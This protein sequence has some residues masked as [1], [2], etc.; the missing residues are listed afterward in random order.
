MKLFNYKG[1]SQ[2]Y[3]IGPIVVKNVC[4]ADLNIGVAKLPPGGVKRID[5]DHLLPGTPVHDLW[6]QGF[7]D[8]VKWPDDID[9]E[10]FQPISQANGPTH[11][12]LPLG[13]TWRGIRSEAKDGK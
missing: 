11:Y 1:G 6:H 5:Y 10:S 4:G 13:Y 8:V 3:N 12:R 7:L 9:H 2:K